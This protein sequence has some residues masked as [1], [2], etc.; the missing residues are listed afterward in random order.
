M[1]TSGKSIPKALEP[2]KE[3]WKL[4][5]SADTSNVPKKYFANIDIKHR[6]GRELLELAL[7]ISGYRE[8]PLNLSR[9]KRGQRAV[10]RNPRA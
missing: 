6:A 2:A 7:G 8:E 9:R 10:R 1:I 3:C 5:P 4:P